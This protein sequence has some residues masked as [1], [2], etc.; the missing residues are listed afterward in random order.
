MGSCAADV[1]VLGSIN[2]DIVVDVDAFPRAGETVAGRSLHSHPGGK[3]ANQAV[4]AVRAG[5]R[6][7]MIGAVGAD[8]PGRDALAT[9]Q[10]EGIDCA[11]VRRLDGVPTGTA[12][13]LV[14]ASGEN[15]IV[16]VPG[17][18]GVVDG[19]KSLTAAVCLAQLETPIASVDAFFAAAPQAVK[20]LNAAPAL[21]DA[22]RLFP[23]IDILV[24]NETELAVFAKMPTPLEALDA[25]TLAARRLILHTRQVVIVTLGAR[26][27]LAVSQNGCE[28]V[29]APAVNVVD[30]TG[31]GD[32]FCGVLAA[33]LATG[34]VLS[35]A[36]K[37]AVLAASLSVERAGALPSM[38]SLSEIEA[39]S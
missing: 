25:L 13:I 36:L 10:Q 1:I 34:L 11:S 19:A 32:C 26:G 7:A 15:S 22:A 18:N 37:R 2:A 29:A 12:F 20:I 9:L 3:G 21:D 31:A 4:A 30:T 16:V 33:G 17:A 5:A 6:V 27:A 35:D 24:V 14:D 28:F 38:P 39:L 23:G 8:S